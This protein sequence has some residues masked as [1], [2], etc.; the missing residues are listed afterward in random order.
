MRNYN[1]IIL[2]LGR[3]KDSSATPPY[4]ALLM[5]RIIGSST[6]DLMPVVV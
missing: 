5:R 1:I 6:T 3:G 4:E 2:I